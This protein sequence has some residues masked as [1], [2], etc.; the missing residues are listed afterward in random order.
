M[1]DV[2][3]T[4]VRRRRWLPLVLVGIT[5]AAC[6]AALAFRTHLRGRYWASRLA[7]TADPAERALLVTALCNAGDAGRWGTTVLLDSDQAELR[8]YGVV[9]LQ[10]TRSDWGRQRL[11]AMLDDEDA[12]TRELVALG[13]ALYGDESIILALQERYR[14][15]SSRVAEAACLTLARLAT[16][17]CVAALSA[18]AEEPADV[19]R[20]AA[21][22]DALASIGEPACVP[23]LVRLLE[24]QRT[25]ALPSHAARAAEALRT[26]AGGTV[27]AS[28]AS[29]APAAQ[30]IAEHAAAALRRITGLTLP[31]SAAL[32]AE[33][34]RATAEQWQAWYTAKRTSP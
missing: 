9:V 19:E 15:G 32:S 29:S 28:A 14:H 27:P 12:A 18:L 7:Q 20:R 4:R 8:Q 17:A 23:A 26:N 34:R 16:P 25:A 6:V 22:V 2:Q 21:L 10:H 3:Q 1:S 13:L 11:L 30:I 24:D 33:E 31:F 5:A